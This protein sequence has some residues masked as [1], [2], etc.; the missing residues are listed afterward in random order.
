MPAVECVLHDQV[1]SCECTAL[2]ATKGTTVQIKI[3]NGRTFLLNDDLFI[4]VPLNIQVIAT[5]NYRN[6]GEPSFSKKNTDREENTLPKN[7]LSGRM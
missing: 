6:D 5:I 3:Q 2:S 7:S 4:H 1:V